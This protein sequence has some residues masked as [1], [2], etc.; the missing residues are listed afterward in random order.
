MTRRTPPTRTL[1]RSPGSRSTQAPGQGAARRV[2]RRDCRRGRR[3]CT[4]TTGTPM[5]RP[6]RCTTRSSSWRARYGFDSWPKL[7]AFVDGITVRR[8]VD[9][10][11]AAISTPC[12]RWS[13]ARPEL[14]HLDV[15]ENDEHRALHHAVLRRRPDIVRFLMQ[16]GADARKGIW[17]HRGAT[18]RVHARRRAW[19]RRD[20]PRSSRRKNAAA[21]KRSARAL[22]PPVAAGLMDAFQRGDEDAMIATLDAHPRA[23]PR[24]GSHRPDGAPLGGGVPVAS[25]GGLAAGSRRRS[26]SAREE[27]RDATGHRWTRGG[28][29]RRR[30]QQPR[31]D[32][33]DGWNAARPRRGTALRARP[34]R[35]E[36]RL[37]A[38]AP[39]PTA[40]STNGHG[41]VSHA[42][43]ADR[44][45]MLALLLDMGLD[46]DE[47]GRVDGLEEVVPTWGEPL[48]ACAISAGSIAMAGDS[49]GAR[50]QSQHQRLRG[51]L[52]AVRSV[53]EA[54]RRR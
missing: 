6:S 34:S 14:V 48:R 7:K 36:T 4:R 27:R 42:V 2:S 25:A 26:G 13:T 53:Q 20:R 3:K 16:Q 23:G 52:R 44:P 49:A 12:G 11:R 46:P 24:D 38:R 15:A 50:R 29:S 8:L 39:S 17:P 31:L 9:A 22:P 37:A 51:K 1:R 21:P 47:A 19:L 45:D 43:T 32:Q 54:R 40:C 30:R 10:V 5:P 41:L 33:I 18:T 35:R 28:R